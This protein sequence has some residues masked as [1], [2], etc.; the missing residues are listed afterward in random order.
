MRETRFVVGI[1][2]VLILTLLGIA[3]YGYAAGRWNPLPC[4]VGGE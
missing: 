1:T 3:V 2:L 4:V